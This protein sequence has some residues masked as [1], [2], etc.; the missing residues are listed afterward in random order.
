MK[1]RKPLGN[2][3][4]TYS[5]GLKFGESKGSVLGRISAIVNSNS[6]IA[7]KFLELKLMLLLVEIGVNV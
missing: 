6:F 3:A 7:S 2:I 5:I 1:N 4:F